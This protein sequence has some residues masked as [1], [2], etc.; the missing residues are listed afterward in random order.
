M[1][2]EV[3]ALMMHGTWRVQT[4]LQVPV[5]ETVVYHFSPEMAVLPLLQ[6][7]AP[8]DPSPKNCIHAGIAVFTALLPLHPCVLTPVWVH[9]WPVVPL[10]LIPP[11][12]NWGEIP[13]H[14]ESTSF[15]VTPP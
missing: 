8:S 12:R 1:V 11:A 14:A 4:K 6:L 10:G 7:S 3:E 5:T 13:I 15:P 9:T 2:I